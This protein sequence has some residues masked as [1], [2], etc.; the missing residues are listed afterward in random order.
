[1]VIEKE[2][3]KAASAGIAE[4]LEI[5]DALAKVPGYDAFIAQHILL[6]ATKDPTIILVHPTIVACMI[7]AAFAIGFMYARN[8]AKAEAEVTKLNE[9]YNLNT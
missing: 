5:A 3:L 1:M 7:Q 6:A 9:L 2:K 4:S 8:E